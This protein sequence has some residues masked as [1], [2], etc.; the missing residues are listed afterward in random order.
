VLIVDDSAEELYL[1]TE[2]LRGHD[3]RLNG[4]NGVD[5]AY[6][7]ALRRF[8]SHLSEASST[9]RGAYPRRASKLFAAT[10]LIRFMLRFKTR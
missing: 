3:L 6:E 9:F 5:Q 10:E 8:N 1:L 2:M 7:L 4:A